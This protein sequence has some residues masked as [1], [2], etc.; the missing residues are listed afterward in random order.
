[1]LYYSTGYICTF[2]FNICFVLCKFC[3]GLILWF[4]DSLWYDGLR[5]EWI[6]DRL[7]IVFSRAVILCGWLGSKCQLTFFIVLRVRWQDVNSHLPCSYTLWDPLSVELPTT[8][9][10]VIHADKSAAERCSRAGIVQQEISLRI[11]CWV[12]RRTR[13]RK[14]ASSNPGR[15]GA[16]IFFSRVNFVCWLF[17]Q[18][19]FHPHVAA[20]AHKRPQLFC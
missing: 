14:V 2:F 8:T 7:N 18:C 20:V 17:I 5:A 9:N 11:A 10:R 16:R 12:A 6:G 13:N 4:L 3:S 15:S 1:M 19:P